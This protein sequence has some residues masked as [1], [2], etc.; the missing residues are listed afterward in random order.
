MASGVLS[1]A[2]PPLVGPQ[3]VADGVLNRIRAVMGGGVAGRLAGF[4]R[5]EGAGF[6]LSLCERQ[7][8]QTVRVAGIV[9]GPNRLVVTTPSFLPKLRD[10]C[11]AVGSASEAQCAAFSDDRPKGLVPRARG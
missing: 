7:N 4:P 8:G 1:L 10:P 3:I 11:T 5:E 9:G 2:A 6:F